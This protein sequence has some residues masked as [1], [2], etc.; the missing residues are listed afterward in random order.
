VTASPS[1]IREI[2]TYSERFIV[3]KIS[4]SASTGRHC[5]PLNDEKEG[6][7]EQNSTAAATHCLIA[8][9]PAGPSTG[10]A[11]AA[12]A[13][14]IWLDAALPVIK[15]MPVVVR[16]MAPACGKTIHTQNA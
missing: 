10:N 11:R 14:P 5:R 12:V 9:T 8:T 7:M 2:A 6:R 13:A 4:A 3:A 16:D 1:P 15:A